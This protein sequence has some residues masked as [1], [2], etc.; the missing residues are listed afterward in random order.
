MANP[1]TPYGFRAVGLIDGSAP[2]FGVFRNAGLNAAT[3][4]NKI[5][6]GDVLLPLSGGYFDVA[7]VTGGGAAI[8]GILGDLVIWPS[9]GRR[10]T[11]RQ[12][13]WPGTPT[14]V[15]SGG[16]VGLSVEAHPRTIFQVRTTGTTRAVVATDIGSNINFNVGGG[17][18][19]LNGLS[20][21]SA[22]D[23]TIASTSTLPFK[24]Y[25]IVQTP[26]SD[27]T[28]LY[29]EIFVIFNNLTNP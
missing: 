29:N 27:P 8:G 2:T 11:A 7:T 24:I 18:N 20:S 23:N 16:L 4:T 22:D 12:N 6:Q 28:S 19:T 17:G 1:N 10:M 5:F 25:G 15:V 14:D 13:W 21:M 26:E 9:A 3:N